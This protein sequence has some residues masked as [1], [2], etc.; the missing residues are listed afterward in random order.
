MPYLSTGNTA[1]TFYKSFGNG[2]TIITGKKAMDKH[3]YYEKNSQFFVP[4]YMPYFRRLSY[5]LINIENCNLF[6]K[7]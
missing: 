1:F 3:N 4:T 7:D 5:T 6:D 2:F